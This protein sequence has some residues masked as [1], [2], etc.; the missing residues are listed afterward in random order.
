MHVVL[1]KCVIEEERFAEQAVEHMWLVHRIYFS[2]RIT[3]E[4]LKM[5]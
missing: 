4:H 2:W 3:E 5:A 1:V